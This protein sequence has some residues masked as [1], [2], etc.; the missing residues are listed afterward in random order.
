[1][2]EAVIA[3]LS[4]LRIPFAASESELHE[5]IGRCLGE[6]GLPYVHEA[7]LGTGCRIDFLS[8]DIGIEVKK[9]KPDRSTL[10]RQLSRYASFD[11]VSALVVVAPRGISL[12]GAIGGKPL[13]YVALN[14]LWGV[15]L[16]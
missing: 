15:A 11:A 13:S 9:E 7:R 16:P 2:Q 1:M 6:A 10:L 5:Q 12:P 4:A 14:R 8:G 3:A